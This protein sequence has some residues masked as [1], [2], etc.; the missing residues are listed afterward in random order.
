LSLR[1]QSFLAAA[2]QAHSAR[3]IS[4]AF[5]K[6]RLYLL[7]RDTERERCPISFGSYG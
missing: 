4:S 5:K 3:R 1:K 7:A 6:Q 2:A